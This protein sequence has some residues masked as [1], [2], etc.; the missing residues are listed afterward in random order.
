M[1]PSLHKLLYKIG[2]KLHDWNNW[3]NI[4]GAP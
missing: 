1:K 4:V 2:K 3:D